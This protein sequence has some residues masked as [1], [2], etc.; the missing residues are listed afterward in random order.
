M[1]RR[2]TDGLS[3]DTLFSLRHDFLMDFFLINVTLV[4]FSEIFHYYGRYL[5]PSML[6][7]N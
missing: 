4:R 6:R 7:K 2:E 5:K 3:K 1:V